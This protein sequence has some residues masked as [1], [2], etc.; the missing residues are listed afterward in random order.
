MHTDFWDRVQTHDIHVRVAAST[1]DSGLVLSTRCL[2]RSLESGSGPNEAIFS[3]CTTPIKSSVQCMTPRM[4]RLGLS[5]RDMRHQKEK[6]IRLSGSTNET[7]RR[8]TQNHSS[9]FPA[10]KIETINL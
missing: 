8:V 4:I 6:Y 10:P 3:I 5:A 2:D 9:L 7:V 1:H